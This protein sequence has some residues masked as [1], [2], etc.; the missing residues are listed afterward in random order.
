MKAYV[1][2]TDGNWYR[3]LADRP[4]LQEVNFW[5]PASSQAFR[6]LQVGEPFYF[7][8]KSP[9]NR[10]VGGGFFS[11]FV[12]LPISE[13]WNL[14]RE[15]NGAASLQ[16]MREAIGRYRNQPLA[17]RDDPEIGCV[18]IRD[19]RFFAPDLIADPPP[20]FASSIMQ[21]K[22][23]DLA[24]PAYA[25]YFLDLFHRLTG[26]DVE[27]DLGA[28]WHRQGDVYG[29]PRLQPQRLGQQAFKGVVLDA[30]QRRCAITGAKIRPVLQAAHILP[31]PSGGE[32]RLD[33]GLLLRS[34]VHIM[35][36]RGYLSVDPS[37]R[38]M[39]S[40]RLREDFG[41]GEYFYARS[42]RQIDVPE[43]KPD[44]PHREFLEWHADTVFQAA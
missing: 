28:P 43:R 2:V 26:V 29:D 25:G 16:Q 23:Y 5:R 13:A 8:T 17:P 40:P 3:F 22:T 19:T 6:A 21:G 4:Q 11:G 36:D 34:D 42:G 9:D 33:N 14:Y 31:L 30:Y 18:F 38:L 32:H 12:P 41:N 20:N 24:E 1:G 27:I 39:V 37:Y 7:K 35:F 44:R 15:G 10:V